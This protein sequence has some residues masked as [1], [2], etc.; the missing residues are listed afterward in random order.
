MKLIYVAGPYSGESK[1]AVKRNIHEAEIVGQMV[2][3]AGHLPFLPHKNTSFW[4]KWGCLTHFSHSDWLEKYCF[5]MLDRCDALLLVPGWEFSPGAI[6]EF[7]YAEE[8]RM[9]IYFTVEE[10]P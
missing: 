7:E 9:P 6:K 5:P 10:M 1:E 4:D 8:R 2:L 3:A